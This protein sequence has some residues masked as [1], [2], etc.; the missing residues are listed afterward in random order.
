MRAS[1]TADRRLVLTN[2]SI[3]NLSSSSISKIGCGMGGGITRLRC[4]SFSHNHITDTQRNLDLWRW[5][6]NPRISTE[7]R[8]G[9]QEV[10]RWERTTFS[11]ALP[12]RIVS[13]CVSQPLTHNTSSINTRC[14]PP[15]KRFRHGKIA[16]NPAA[17]VSTS[18][19]STTSRKPP[20]F[21][22][23]TRPWIP[24]LNPLVCDQSRQFIDWARVGRS[25][26]KRE[27]ITGPMMRFLD[28]LSD[29]R[30]SVVG[31][32]E[33]GRRSTV[34]PGSKF[35]P[36]NSAAGLMILPDRCSRSVTKG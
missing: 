18:F 35:P 28:D 9:C 27:G 34:F 31:I 10:W 3:T 8:G 6:Y 30:R 15:S 33:P 4:G 26:E 29:F 2:S 32:P 5:Y 17:T 20:A 13:V 19:L 12:A 16:P 36:T 23:R 22:D 25:V 1:E 7:R 21:G 11:R 14:P 24:G